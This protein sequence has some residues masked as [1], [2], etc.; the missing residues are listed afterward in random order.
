MDQRKD[1]LQRRAEAALW[2]GRKAVHQPR[3]DRL[4]GRAILEQ[5][6]VDRM[7]RG[8]GRFFARMKDPTGEGEEKE[9]M[10]AAEAKAAFEQ[11]R[12][13]LAEA[14]RK[15][16]AAE[17]AH[18]R[19]AAFWK[20]TDAAAFLYEEKELLDWAML[21]ELGGRLAQEC[22]SCVKE[23]KYGLKV[24]KIDCDPKE[25]AA[26]QEKMEGLYAMAREF[27]EKSGTREEAP[28]FRYDLRS[29][30]NPKRR[31]PDFGYRPPIIRT[32]QGLG[33][34]IDGADAYKDM[35]AMGDVLYEMLRDVERMQDAVADIFEEQAKEGERLL[36]RMQAGESHFCG[37]DIFGFSASEK[38]LH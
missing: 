37:K 35:I 33:D 36:R 30:E 20:E 19:F 26:L 8:L 9:R 34:L 14:E 31:E 7:E 29:F 15:L 25:Q 27:Y 6:D 10:E 3:M 17:M 21:L 32:V 12:A 4:Q 18:G 23:I 24:F 5:D 28:V 11:A 16:P 38:D 22:E 2:R 1:A 13:W